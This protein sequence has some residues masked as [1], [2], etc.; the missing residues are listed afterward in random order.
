MRIPR[1]LRDLQVERESRFFDFS[2]QRLFHGLDLFFG[3]RRQQ[4]SFCAVVSDAMSQD[5]EGEASVQMLMDA[6]LASG[7]CGAPLGTLDLQ[8]QV[9]KAHRVIPINGALE[10][11]REDHFQVPLPTGYKRPFLAQLPE[12]APEEMVR[13]LTVDVDGSYIAADAVPCKPLIEGNHGSET[14]KLRPGKPLAR[15]PRLEKPGLEKLTLD[16]RSAEPLPA[17]EARPH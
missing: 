2:F 10:S 6:D 5:H 16:V 8:D 12:P 11:L 15:K 7:Q 1:I 4:F 3:Q 14:R 17:S 9:V 13:N